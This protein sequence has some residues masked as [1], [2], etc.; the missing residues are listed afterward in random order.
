MRNQKLQMERRAMS[1]DRIER[2][3]DIDAPIDVVW[4]VLTQPDHMRRWFVDETDVASRPGG[5]G[6][7][8]WTQR[9]ERGGTGVNVRV[10][11]VEPP[12]FFSFRWNFPDGAEPDETNAPLVEFTLEETG[13]ESTRLV[14]VER[15]I[16]GLARPTEER[17]RYLADHTGGWATIALRLLEYVAEVRGTVR[18]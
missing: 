17:E 9:S 11:R 1:G 6:R 7:F 14:L 16:A 3:I 8:V 18:R 2:E 5:R 15:G 13:A 12:T 10:E 4:E